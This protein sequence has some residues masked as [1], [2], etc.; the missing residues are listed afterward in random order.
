M[1]V[2][3]LSSTLYEIELLRYYKNY[4]QVIGSDH[5]ATP[6]AAGRSGGSA[7]PRR[8]QPHLAEADSW[9]VL[10]LRSP[11]SNAQRRIP[12]PLK[13]NQDPETEGA[14]CAPPPA[15]R[16]CQSHHGNGIEGEAEGQKAPIAPAPSTPQSG[17]ALLSLMT[18]N[19]VS[20]SN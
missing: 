4:T 7:L 12:S 18:T 15:S 19:M 16:R 5:H 3:L 11:R 13:P 6:T 1:S 9:E 14:V 10:E 8:S 20:G 17:E 2:Y